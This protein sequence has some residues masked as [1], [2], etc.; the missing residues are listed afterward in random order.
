[1]SEQKHT[2]GPWSAANSCSILIDDEPTIVPSHVAMRFYRTGDRGPV[3]VTQFIADCNTNLPEHV[4]NAHLIAAAPDYHDRAHHL[5]MLVLQS[6][7]Y[8]TDSEIQ[9]LTDDVLAIH[10]KAEGR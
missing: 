6:D 3:R 4:A 9:R 8:R 5:A 7:L 2:P 1:M 10:A